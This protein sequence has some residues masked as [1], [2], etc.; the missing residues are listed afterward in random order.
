MKRLTDVFRQPDTQRM[1]TAAER[2]HSAL[3][4]WFLPGAVYTFVGAGGKTTALKR[5]ASHLAGT[6]VKARM[7]TTTKV[8]MDEFAGFLVSFVRE[9]AEFERAI[10]DRA[11]TR[12]VVAGSGPE[13]GKY[14]GVEPALI[15]GVRIRADT[16]LLVEGDGSRKRPMK[17]PGSHEPVI[18]SNTS[19]VFA[20]MGASAF[21][22]PMDEPHCY[23]FERALTLVGKTGSFFEARE[24]AHLAGDPQGCFK[25]VK[26][27]MGFVLLLNQGDLGEKR[28]TACEALWLARQEHGI[29]GAVVSFE[30]GELYEST[31]V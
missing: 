24:I 7:T 22:E 4:Q 8:G 10:A 26:S 9:A 17:V 27:G 31:S 30:K 14:L 13:Q 3:A 6:G 2:F 16:V 21:D 25:G 20:V 23:N 11:R 15:E 28:E 18:P 12:L 29:R 19:T 1:Q 5:V